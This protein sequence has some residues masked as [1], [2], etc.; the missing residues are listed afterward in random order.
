MSGVL[1]NPLCLSGNHVAEI[2]L[3]GIDTET[4]GN[5]GREAQKS[6]VPAILADCRVENAEYPRDESGCGGRG[7]VCVPGNQTKVPALPI[8]QEKVRRVVGVLRDNSVRV[9]L[10]ENEPAIPRDH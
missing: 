3:T 10:E 1:R 6:D 2:H 7:F 9:A 5:I 8:E 4:R